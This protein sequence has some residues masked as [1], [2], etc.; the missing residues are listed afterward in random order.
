MSN[1]M[2]EAKQWLWVA[3]AWL[4]LFATYGAYLLYLRS[5]AKRQGDDL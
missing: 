1:M 4:E 3:V 2:P 5:R